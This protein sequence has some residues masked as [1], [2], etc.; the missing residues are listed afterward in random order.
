[1][2]KAAFMVVCK[3]MV[4]GEHFAVLLL[5]IGSMATEGFENLNHDFTQEN[6]QIL[7]FNNTSYFADLTITQPHVI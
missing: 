2:P 7:H 1:M 5:K 6:S 3:T 4:S